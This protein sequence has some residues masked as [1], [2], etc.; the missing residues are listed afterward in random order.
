M[1]RGMIKA[2]LLSANNNGADQSAR[3]C[4]KSLTNS[5]FSIFLIVCSNISVLFQY[6]GFVLV[7]LGTGT[8][9]F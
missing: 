5:I 4:T 7:N 9:H 2:A 3:M 1:T 8:F 6:F